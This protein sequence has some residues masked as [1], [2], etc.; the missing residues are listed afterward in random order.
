MAEQSTATLE[1][2]GFVKSLRKGGVEQKAV[3]TAFRK[4][5]NTGRSSESKGNTGKLE[6]NEDGVAGRQQ[7]A[8]RG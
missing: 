1:G 8:D 6:E 3:S 4:Q 7:S 5:R 2:S